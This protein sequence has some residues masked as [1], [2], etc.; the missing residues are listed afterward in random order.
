MKL[1]QI[2]KNVHS[3]QNKGWLL[4]LQF[5]YTAIHLFQIG[6][7]LQGPSWGFFAPSELSG[8]ERLGFYGCLLPAL[9]MAVCQYPVYYRLID[10]YTRFR[11][12]IP[13][14]FIIKGKE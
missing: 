6:W 2:Y 1:I 3:G 4:R 10:K 13:S 12:C 11:F 5:R 9:D 7:K 8:T 14:L